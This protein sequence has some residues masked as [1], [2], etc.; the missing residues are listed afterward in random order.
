MWV[1][2]TLVGREG[3]ESSSERDGRRQTASARGARGAR[4]ESS[5]VMCVWRARDR[6][7]PH[8]VTEL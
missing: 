1:C 2:W 4:G 5:A 6:A 3:R 7:Q 8:A